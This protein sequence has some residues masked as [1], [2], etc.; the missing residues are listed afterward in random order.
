MTPEQ[1]EAIP[2]YRRKHSWSRSSLRSFLSTASMMPEEQ[3]EAPAD[4]D[5]QI[6]SVIDET[7]EMN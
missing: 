1:L 2:D 3:D 4:A 6:E 5:E 7:S